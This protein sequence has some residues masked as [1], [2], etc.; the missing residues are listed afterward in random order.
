[1]LSKHIQ[2]QSRLT[3]SVAAVAGL[4]LSPGFRRGTPACLSVSSVAPHAGSS[5]RTRWPRPVKRDVT[6]LSAWKGLPAESWPPACI[7]LRAKAAVP[8][9]SV[10][11]AGGSRTPRPLPP[12]PQ[13]G[14]P[15]GPRLCPAS[16]GP[17]SAPRCSLCPERLPQASA[18]SF[19]CFFNYPSTTLLERLPWP[20][21]PT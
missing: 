20:P 21:H 4:P 6:S 15:G 3:R 17:A 12:C 14:P 7:S 5:L 11:P 16:S 1:M 19:L 13:A 2:K 10:S 8:A 9:V 18:S